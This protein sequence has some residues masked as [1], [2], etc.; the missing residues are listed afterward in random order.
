MSF[1]HV[2][3][4]KEQKDKLASL[5]HIAA[6]YFTSQVP[7]T[8]VTAGTYYKV[9]A[10]FTPT[11]ENGFTWNGTL[12][13]WDYTGADTVV[14]VF[15]TCVGSHGDS[16]QNHQVDWAVF[17]NGGIVQAAP[18]G[19]AIDK[20]K[21]NSIAVMVPAVTVTAGDYLEVYTTIDDDGDVV[22]SENMN[23]LAR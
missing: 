16:T 10:V 6:G 17:K 21:A 7:T 20:L 15:V 4:T 23:F 18:A 19:A 2:A 5:G 13:R 3:F 12:K 14:S 22:Y 11:S 9:D 1:K 8:V